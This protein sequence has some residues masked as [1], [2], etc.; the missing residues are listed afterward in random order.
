[1]S[2]KDKSEKTGAPAFFTAP[3]TRV[4]IKPRILFAA[5]TLLLVY[6]CVMHY[7]LPG[8]IVTVAALA[9]M[10]V[11]TCVIY[12]KEMLPAN[13][14]KYKA[15]HFLFWTVICISGIFCCAGL[16]EQAK[17]LGTLLPVLKTVPFY[18][19]IAGA[20]ALVVVS[21]KVTKRLLEKTVHILSAVLLLWAFSG[22]LKMNAAML[23]LA[24]G[25]TLAFYFADMW[26]LA[27]NA[28][29][30][31][32]KEHC[33]VYGPVQLLFCAIPAL[34]VFVP[35][36][37][38]WTAHPAEMLARLLTPVPFFSMLAAAL[39]MAVICVRFGAE[40][41]LSNNETA[42]FS[43]GFIALLLMK[44][45]LVF[46]FRFAALLPAAYILFSLP[47]IMYAGPDSLLS[48][49]TERVGL[50][51]FALHMILSGLALLTHMLLYGGMYICSAAV[52]ISAYLIVTGSALAKLNQNKF[53][54][55]AY[56]ALVYP[57]F[58]AVCADLGILRVI[59]A[60]IHGILMLL[61]QAAGAVWDMQT[62]AEKQVEEHCTGTT[63]EL[64]LKHLSSGK[65]EKLL[66]C[67]K[68]VIL[69]GYIIL[70]A[71]MIRNLL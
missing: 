1:M 59:P 27:E 44:L 70:T 23:L 43:T 10:F 7:T 46:P 26:M 19:K 67:V 42:F 31:E 45:M 50:S 22:A 2:R 61:L 63:K 41:S 60:V 49:F 55:H 54:W 51:P 58:L 32:C 39:G 30:T 5:H 65:Q 12:R 18:L 25:L 6:L 29:V 57:V 3:D 15:G 11:S 35:F 21:E 33:P 34:Y 66:Q 38:D 20:A 69:G 53:R 14:V 13:P 4:L 71:L 68:T 47:F 9:G 17:R 24:G 40:D 56:L 62:A 48:K 8:L 28:A 52:L 37:N 64:L 16:P 36:S